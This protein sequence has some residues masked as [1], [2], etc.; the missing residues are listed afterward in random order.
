MISTKDLD[1]LS[2]MFELDFTACK[3]ANH[4]YEEA[5]RLVFKNETV[6]IIPNCF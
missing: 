4:Y 5:K 1:Y 2:D 3:I 6:R